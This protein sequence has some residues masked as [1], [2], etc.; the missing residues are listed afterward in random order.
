MYSA[1][2]HGNTQCLIDKLKPVLEENQVNAFLAGHDHNNQ[3]GV[4]GM[5]G[6]FLLLNCERHHNCAAF[7]YYFAH[8]SFF[9][10]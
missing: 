3:V 8:Y 9:A 5:I 7:A 10:Y 6:G 1:G 2:M 4:T